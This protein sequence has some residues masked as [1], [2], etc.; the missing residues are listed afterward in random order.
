MLM[1]TKRKEVMICSIFCYDNNDNINDNTECAINHRWILNANE[2]DIHAYNG[3]ISFHFKQ[4]YF[5]FIFCKK[6]NENDDHQPE[7]IS[8]TA[9]SRSDKI[10]HRAQ[11]WAKKIRPRYVAAAPQ[12]SRLNLRFQMAPPKISL[13]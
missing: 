8:G 5:I 1:N 12:S 11:G 7:Y 10:A 13:T 4:K 9:G 2:K 6:Y 3:K